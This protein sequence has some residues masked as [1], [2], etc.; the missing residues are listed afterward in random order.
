[1]PE[2]M[3]NLA[4]VLVSDMGKIVIGDVLFATGGAGVITFDDIDY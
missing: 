4:T 2:E 3:A 1:M